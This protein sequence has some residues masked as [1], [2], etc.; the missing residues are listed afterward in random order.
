ME[1]SYWARVFII[2]GCVFVL[3]GLFLFALPRIPGLH[4]LGRLPGDIVYRKGNFVFYF[5]LMTSLLISL[6]LTLLFTLIL[7]R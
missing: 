2:V 5:P 3:I 7:R 6:F 4:R 1:V